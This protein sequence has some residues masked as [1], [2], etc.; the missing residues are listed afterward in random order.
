MFG[1]ACTGGQASDVAEEI[2]CVTYSH[3]QPSISAEAKNGMGLP[4]KRSVVDALP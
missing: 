1:E 2:K 3:A 4:G